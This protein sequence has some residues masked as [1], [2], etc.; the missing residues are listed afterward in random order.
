MGQQGRRAVSGQ[1]GWW[2]GEWVSGLVN[3]SVVGKVD[4]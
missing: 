4:R 2:V 1:A 3:K